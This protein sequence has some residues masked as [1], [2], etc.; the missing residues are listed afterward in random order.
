MSKLI[1]GW[2]DLRLYINMVKN[3][4]MYIF[5]FCWYSSV[6]MA[7]WPGLN[8][9]AMWE[10]RYPEFQKH[11]LIT[12]TLIT[13]LQRGFDPVLLIG[14]SLLWR[15]LR[16]CGIAPLLKEPCVKTITGLLFLLQLLICLCC[17][18]CM[19]WLI[20]THKKRPVILRN[21][22]LW[23]PEIW[24]SLGIVYTVPG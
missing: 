24:L 12:Y 7:E 2:I 8:R 20:Y 18:L 22:A 1:K 23:L 11:S 21:L 14:H 4:Y 13:E 16:L 17:W 19:L 9:E 15:V 6:L 3:G 5:S 10:C